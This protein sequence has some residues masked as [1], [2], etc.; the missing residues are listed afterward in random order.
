MIKLIGSL[1]A[2]LMYAKV[3]NMSLRIRVYNAWCE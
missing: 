1:R 2:V 3:H